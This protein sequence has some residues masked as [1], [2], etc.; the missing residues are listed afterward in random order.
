MKIKLIK[1]VDAM[2]A[3]QRGKPMA[4]NAYIRK[5]K[6][7]KISCQSFFKKLRK[8]EQIQSKQEERNNNQSRNQ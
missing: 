4:L 5:E 8:E 6:R 3:E 2:K 7:S 1:I